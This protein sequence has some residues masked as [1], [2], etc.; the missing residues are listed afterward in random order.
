LDEMSFLRGSPKDETAL[1]ASVPG[2]QVH[3]KP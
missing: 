2:A 3:P 1:M